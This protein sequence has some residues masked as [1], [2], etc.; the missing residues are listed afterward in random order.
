MSHWDSNLTLVLNKAEAIALSAAIL[1][2]GT[3]GHRADPLEAVRKKL[4]AGLDHRMRDQEELEACIGILALEYERQQPILVRDEDG[5]YVAT[6][7][8]AHAER[9]ALSRYDL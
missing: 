9:Q 4:R 8:E 5:E 7:K 2:I 1:A 3:T 6:D